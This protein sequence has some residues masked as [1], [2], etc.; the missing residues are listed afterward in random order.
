ME[1]AFPG[2]HPSGEPHL[3]NRLG[4]GRSWVAPQRRYQCFFCIV[5]H[6]GVTQPHHPAAP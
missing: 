6:H 5:D 4:A 2:I 1:T 3:G